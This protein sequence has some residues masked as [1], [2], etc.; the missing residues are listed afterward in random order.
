MDHHFFYDEKFYNF[1]NDE[2]VCW[3]FILFEASKS[4]SR[5]Q[6]RVNYEHASRIR[7][8]QKNTL[9]RTIKK[10]LLKKIVT[11]RTTTG[12]FQSGHD[13]VATL[14]DITEQDKTEQKTLAQSDDFAF[15]G[16]DLEKLYEKYP[17]KI[18]KQRG[19][20]VAQNQ[21][22]SLDDYSLLS[23][24]I[25]RYREHCRQEAKEPRFIMHFSTFMN[26]WKD[27]VDERT[28]DSENF[29]IGAKKK[30]WGDFWEKV[31]EMGATDGKT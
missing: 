20:R 9:D 13:L 19:M 14:Q 31:G 7:N 12:R 1:T 22:K 5:G 8:I 21:I 4:S 27:W 3:F 15:V 11:E 23:A 24:A 6:Y 28:G 18:G 30:D 29:S 26:S 25:D 17:R 16:F 2:V 10:L